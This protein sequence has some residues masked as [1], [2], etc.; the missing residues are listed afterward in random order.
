MATRARPAG[1]AARHRCR[2]LPRL[3]SG[4][5]HRI[6]RR[7]ATGAAP[8]PTGAHRAGHPA[9]LAGRP[10]SRS[11]HGTPERRAAAKAG[12][13]ARRLDAGLAGCGSR[14]LE[15]ARPW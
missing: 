14:Y 5:W 2:R 8:A 10:A 13:A 6:P 1:A 12:R 15:G 3:A 11:G 9:I 7:A 4:S